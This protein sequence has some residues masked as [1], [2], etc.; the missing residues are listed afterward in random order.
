MP[1]GVYNTPYN[2]QI[3]T[4]RN[5]WIADNSGQG[6][7][8]GRYIVPSIAFKNGTFL[9]PDGAGKYK[10]ATAGDAG[11]VM[12]QGISQADDV[13]FASTLK[14]RNVLPVNSI[15]SELNGRFAGTTPTLADLYKCYSLNATGD[16]I[17]SASGAVAPTGKQFRLISLLG[18]SNAF[19]PIG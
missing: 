13:D 6:N 5:F 1:T 8:H 10:I 14:V 3:E 11:L 17:D 18:D 12:T 15:E 4:A 16:A 2:T 19:A 9:T 7:A